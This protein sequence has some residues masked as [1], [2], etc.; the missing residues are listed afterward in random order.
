[1]ARH[2]VAEDIGVLRRPSRGR[3]NQQAQATGLAG[4]LANAARRMPLEGLAGVPATGEHGGRG[5]FKMPRFQSELVEEE[6]SWE[7]ELPPA[8][9]SDIANA[10]ADSMTARE[11]E[12]ADLDVL[13]D[14]IRTDEDRGLR[15]LGQAPKTSAA[16]RFC[17]TGLGEHFFVLEDEL[18]EGKV[19]VGFAGFQEFH[20]G[21]LMTHLYLMAKS[22]G[23]AHRL[24]PQLMEMASNQYPDTTFVVSTPDQAMARLL[25]G[26]GFEASYTLKWTPRVIVTPT[27]TPIDAGVG[28][29]TD[30]DS[31]ADLSPGE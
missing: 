10:L 3:E 31:G 19:I 14:A 27:D 11:A 24:I 23:D 4:K 28:P 16:M 29:D 17:L 7:G 18:P 13:W 20:P 22:R 30:S 6:D 9:P 26:V 12:E 8:E 25:R 21:H 5:P 15:F 1:M 2:K